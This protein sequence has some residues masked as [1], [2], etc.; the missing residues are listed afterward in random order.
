MENKPPQHLLIMLATFR[1]MSSFVC[2]DTGRSPMYMSKKAPGIQPILGSQPF[3]VK[4]VV[5]SIQLI[6]TLQ[7]VLRQRR[8]TYCTNP[9]YGPLQSGYLQLHKYFF[10]YKTSVY[11]IL[12]SRKYWRDLYL[13]K[14]K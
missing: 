3:A 5:Y 11:N 6:N 1:P 7:S 2:S 14:Q 12:Q 13:I 9:C 10:H 8:F 4:I